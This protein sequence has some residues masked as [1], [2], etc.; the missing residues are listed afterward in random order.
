[1]HDTHKLYRHVY[2]HVCLCAYVDLPND[3]PIGDICSAPFDV[4]LPTKQDCEML[5]RDFVVLISRV[6]V[7]YVPELKQ[8]GD[9]VPLHIPH[10]MSSEM[11]K[12]SEMVRLEIIHFGTLYTLRCRPLHGKSLNLGYGLLRMCIYVC[13]F[14]M[15]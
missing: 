7:Q 13:S 1:M 2:V 14:C 4:F 6:L 5:R 15:K 8:F 3:D 9:V 12:K 10:S 11:T